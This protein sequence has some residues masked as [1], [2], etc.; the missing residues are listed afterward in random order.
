MSG[1]DS[2]LHGPGLETTG[3]PTIFRSGPYRFFFYSNEGTEAPH[4]HVE[5]EGRVAKVWLTPVS[6]RKSGGLPD[7]ELGKIESIV[8]MH[9]E[10]L[11]HA[12]KAFF[13]AQF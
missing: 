2:P 12:W 4:V 5:R 8:S 11:L 13:D 6:V 10:D 1:V 9:R 7:H 3:L